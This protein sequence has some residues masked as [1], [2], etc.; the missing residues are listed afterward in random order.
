MAG[1]P[2]ISIYAMKL[3]SMQQ[4]RMA[5]EERS[6]RNKEIE[7]VR[8]NDAFD[9]TIKGYQANLQAEAALDKMQFGVQKQMVDQRMAEMETLRKEREL[10]L[11]EAEAFRQRQA[12]ISAGREFQTGERVAG[13]KA[14]T[15][16]AERHEDWLTSDKYIAAQER[17]YGAKA[18]ATA[19]AKERKI[20]FQSIRQDRKDRITLANKKIAELNKNIN[21]YTKDF[22][23]VT[24]PEM[25]KWQAARLQLEAYRNALD[26]IV[27]RNN[28]R[29]VEEAYGRIG[30]IIQQHNSSLQET[31]QQIDEHFRGLPAGEQAS[32]EQMTEAGYASKSWADK[33]QED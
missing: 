30:K 16:E 4:Q 9:R 1:D 19:P 21:K 8:I 29:S 3:Q 13:Q 32:R 24:S 5:E 22:G 6:I 15:K 33:Y 17:I 7:R 14:K 2:L 26:A 12:E 28:P 23:M 20:D 11:K 31:S 27:I 10:K 25:E 18:A